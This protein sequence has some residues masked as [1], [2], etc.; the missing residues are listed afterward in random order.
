MRAL[1]FMQ[2]RQSIMKR[3]VEDKTTDRIYE[4]TYQILIDDKKDFLGSI[5]VSRDITEKRRIEKENLQYNQKLHLEITGLTEK[6]NTLF[7]ESLTSLVNTLEAKDIY[8]KGHSERVTGICKN[9]VM[10]LYGSTQ[11]LLNIE[12]AAPD[13]MILEK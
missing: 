13:C 2:E 8:T 12:P 3:M 6:L 7:Y 10:Q 5:V 4:N 9:Y 11:F 1:S